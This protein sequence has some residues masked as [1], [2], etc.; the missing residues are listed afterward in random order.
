MGEWQHGTFGCFDNCGLCIITWLL[1]CYRVRRE[2]ILILVVY[3]TVFILPVFSIPS[4]NTL[5]QMKR[6][7]SKFKSCQ[8]STSTAVSGKWACLKYDE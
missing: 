8:L 5:F 4:L 3:T 2:L 7:M 1:P 6:E